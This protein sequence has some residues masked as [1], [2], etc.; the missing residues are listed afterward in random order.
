MLYILSFDISCHS[1]T[2]DWRNRA[3]WGPWER[4]RQRGGRRAA[5]AG[6]QGCWRGAWWQAPR[7]GPVPDRRAERHRGGER[8]TDGG[9]GTG[10]E[11]SGP[12]GRPLPRL[13]PSLGIAWSG[14]RRRGNTYLTLLPLV[15]VRRH[16]HIRR[17]KSRWM[18]KCQVQALFFLGTTE[19]TTN[20][21]K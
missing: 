1:W 5:G 7:L 13:L 20:A 9:A 12:S 14:H 15:S 21:L 19:V 3:G 2:E 6:A 4:P 17:W 8:V 18:M 16:G 10:A 11:K